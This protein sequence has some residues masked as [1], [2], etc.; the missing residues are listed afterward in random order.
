MECVALLS[1]SRYVRLSLISV[2][3]TRR[4]IQFCSPVSFQLSTPTFEEKKG[5]RF[6]Y[7]VFEFKLSID[8]LNLFLNSNDVLLI[9]NQ[10]L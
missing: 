1:N 3:E 10:Q 5:T 9:M 7:D 8:H 4:E 2:S 6:N